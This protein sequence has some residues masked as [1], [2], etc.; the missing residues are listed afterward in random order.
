MNAT[1]RKHDDRIR[2]F[3]FELDQL[4]M[5]LVFRDNPEWQEDG[6]DSWF[7]AWLEIQRLRAEADGVELL[8]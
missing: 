1:P 5:E 7:P 3:D 6:K 2:S 4:L 8:N